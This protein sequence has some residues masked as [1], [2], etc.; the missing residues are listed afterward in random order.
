MGRLGD[1]GRCWGFQGLC[2]VVVCA[3]GGGNEGPVC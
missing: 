2:A 1:K 3:Q